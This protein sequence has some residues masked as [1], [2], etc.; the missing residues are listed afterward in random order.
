MIYLK[1][2][3]QNLWVRK[4]TLEIKIDILINNED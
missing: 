3:I 2:K 4:I 1:S